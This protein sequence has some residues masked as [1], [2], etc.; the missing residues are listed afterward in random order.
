M[1]THTRACIHA[2]TPT[3]PQLLSHAFSGTIGGTGFFENFINEARSFSYS[4]D[5]HNTCI[6][7]LNDGYPPRFQKVDLCTLDV[8]LSF[9]L[10]VVV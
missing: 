9:L 3:R 8:V 7:I 5:A 10:C 6:Y 2:H 4:E 1:F